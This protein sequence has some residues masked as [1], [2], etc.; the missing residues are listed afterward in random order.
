MISRRPVVATGALAVGAAAADAAGAAGDTRSKCSETTTPAET[1]IGTV[2]LAAPS[3]SSSVWLPIG[4]VNWSGVTP[5]AL[6]STETVAPDGREST[7]TEPSVGA[8]TG[9]GAG[10]AGA[11]VC[12]AAVCGGALGVASDDRKKKNHTPATTAASASMPAPA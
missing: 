6:P 10:V 7:V 8:A 4:S 1:V 9:A 11:A 12:A 2:R 5:R 3:P